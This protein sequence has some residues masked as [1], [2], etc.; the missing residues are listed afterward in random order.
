MPTYDYRCLKCKK[1]FEQLQR[2]TE[3]ALKKCPK[4]GGKAERLI[5]GGTGLIFKGSGF[6]ITDYKNKKPG[7]TGSPS[8]STNKK[9]DKPANGS[10]SSPSSS[11]KSP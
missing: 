6:Y 5:S 1:K 8:G 11:T 7:S 3:P 9:E 4:C 2:I 10:T